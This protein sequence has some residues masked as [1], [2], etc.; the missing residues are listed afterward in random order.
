MSLKNWLITQAK[1]IIT[2]V[3][4]FAI[5]A[6]GFTY[7][8]TVF[9][10][11]ELK[12]YQIQVEQFEQD[13]TIAIDYGDSLLSVIGG[14]QTHNIQIQ[15]QSDHL[16]DSLTDIN[17]QLDG[18][19]PT[20]DSLRSILDTLL[21]D[22]PVPVVE[23][24]SGLES[25]VEVLILGK[26]TADQLAESRLLQ[27]SLLGP[28]LDM[29]LAR[30]DSLM[31]VIELFPKDVPDVERLLGFIPLPSRTTSFVAGTATALVLVLAVIR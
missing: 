22:L 24:I 14:L 31:T 28:S 15:Q 8:G 16:V 11:S 12:E 26:S 2:V 23:Y 10:S 18:L 17:L 30:G 21:V 1:T 19:I 27:L 13:A 25:Q 5:V 29:A 20:V 6:T 9:S 4:F 7:L 3:I